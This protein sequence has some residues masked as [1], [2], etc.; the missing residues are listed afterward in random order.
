LKNALQ[1]AVDV[2]VV[3]QGGHSF[4]HLLKGF[5]GDAGRIVRE[6]FFCQ[7]LGGFEAYWIDK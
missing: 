5:L 6:D 1:V 3:R 7:F 2:E 4:A